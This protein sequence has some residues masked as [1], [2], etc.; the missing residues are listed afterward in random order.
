M[1]GEVIAERALLLAECDT[2]A[3]AL[4][5]LEAGT[6]LPLEDGRVV[7]LREDVPFGHKVGLTSIG[8]GDSVYK[9]GE[10]IGRATREIEPGE[11]V[12]THNCESTR[13]RGDHAAPQNAGGDR[14]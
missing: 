14:Q 12:H 2:V 9:Y 7:F 13:G 4:E 8:A 3:T 11:W 6:E 10:V 1:K 5:D